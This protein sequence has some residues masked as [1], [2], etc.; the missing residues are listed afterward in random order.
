MPAIEI[1]QPGGSSFAI[2]PKDWQ[3][4]GQ[5]GINRYCGTTT[6]PAD[7][8]KPTWVKIDGKESKLA[9]AR[10]RQQRNRQ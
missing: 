9:C 10:Q 4:S 1:G 5:P 3:Y 7:I 8:K 2:E 6:K